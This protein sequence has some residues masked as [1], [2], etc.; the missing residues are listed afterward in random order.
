MKWNLRTLHL[1]PHTIGCNWLSVVCCSML[2]Q[3]L[4]QLTKSPTTREAKHYEP[5]P[6]TPACKTSSIH[7]CWRSLRV[8][9]LASPSICTTSL[10][11]K[12]WFFFSLLHFVLRGGLL[13]I[14]IPHVLQHPWSYKKLQN[15]KTF[16]MSSILI[17]SKLIMILPIEDA[18]LTSSHVDLNGITHVEFG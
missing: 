14:K 8:G 1:A 5:S 18:P 12:A 10:M 2:A 7:M 15:Q 9:S 11:W 16:E 13:C 4:P 6:A 17:S 3:L